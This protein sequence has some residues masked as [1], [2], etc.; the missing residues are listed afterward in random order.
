[1]YFISR[2]NAFY[3]YIAHTNTK[4]RYLATL[5]V[6]VVIGLIGFY[7]IYMPLTSHIMIY[8]TQLAHLQKQQHESDELRVNNKELLERIDT[9]KKNISGHIVAD[10]VKENYCSERMQFVFDTIV[11]AGLALNS[12][13]SC[14]A[15]D[16]AWY[17]KDSAHLQAVG[18]MEQILSFLKTIKYS[19]QLITLSHLAITR[20]KE[21]VLQLSCD[22]AIVV[23][24]K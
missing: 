7:G 11:K 21:N 22:V 9:N 1:M 14:K 3:N 15:K 8:K 18:S 19:N 12:Y 2:N 20:V 10:D 24:K 23:V 13:G 6:L 5:L 16:K 4:R 17:L